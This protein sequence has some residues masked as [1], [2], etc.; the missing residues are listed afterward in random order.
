VRS[1]VEEKAGG[2]IMG[3]TADLLSDR[4]V[5][6]FLVDGCVLVHTDDAD[7]LHRSI[8]DQ[9][10]AVF[11]SEGNPGNNLLPR[12]PDIQQ[13]WDHPKVRGALTSLLGPDY[14]LNP[15]RHPHLNP[16]GSK[17]Q[18][19]HKD[20]YVWD[21]NLRSPRFRWILALYYP[22][23]VTL[24]MGPTGILP[25]MHPYPTVSDPDPGRCTEAD[26]P[27]VGPAGTV[28]LVNF[29]AWHRAMPNTSD[30]KRYMLK[31]QFA[32][33]REPDAPTWDHHSEEWQVPVPEPQRAMS[34]HTWRWLRGAGA[35]P[36]SIEPTE[37]LSDLL[38][39]LLSESPARRLYAAY[40]LGLHGEAAFRPLLE[41]L[42]RQAAE[43]EP[44]IEAKTA[45]NAHG[46]NPT[47]LPAAQ[48]L[49]ASGAPAV[50]T[51]LL[52][53]SDPHWLVRVSA[54]E[55]LGSFG[56]AA[57]PA[58]PALAQATTDEHWWVRRA[59]VEA[60]GRIGCASEAVVE[61]LVPHLQDSDRRVRRVSALALAQLGAPVEAALPGLRRMLSDEDRYNRF[62]AELA[63]RRMPLPAAH[64]IVL[65]WLFTSRWCSLT[66]RASLY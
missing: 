11:D 42:R 52:A 59:A 61:A 4:E 20:C 14:I 5:Q 49:L 64:E 60:L 31:F 27:L 48:A 40:E 34:H 26:L 23:D 38:A 41:A 13:V 45:D 63:L 30:R 25:G 47:L 46:T 6:Q 33:M 9:L 62:Y 19:W 32:R 24:D 35:S 29:D 51:L 28:A 3:E 18:T 2:S 58:L 12:I 8:Y 65:D 17:G 53:L 16:P 44:A 43:A 1:T 55:V 66:T 39:A 21:H 22:Q 10:E 37:S 57:S 54:A 50:S 15:H 56:P 7:P 36:S